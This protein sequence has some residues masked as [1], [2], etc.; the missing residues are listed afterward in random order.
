MEGHLQRVLRNQDIFLK[1][2]NPPVVDQRATR[3]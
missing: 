3:T 1:R 2:G